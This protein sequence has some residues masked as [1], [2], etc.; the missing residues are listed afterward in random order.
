MLSAS[1]LILV[2]LVALLVF[3]PEKLPELARTLSKVMGDFNRL[4]GDFKE[5]IQREMDQI[6][7][8]VREKNRAKSDALPDSQGA[9]PA[10]ASES[11][12]AAVSEEASSAGEVANGEA[13][14]DAANTEIAEDSSE[15]LPYDDFYSTYE[16]MYYDGDMA[17]QPGDEPEPISPET[18]SDQS[19]DAAPAPADG[20]FSVPDSDAAANPSS[21][22]DSSA[23]GSE[24]P[25]NGHPTAA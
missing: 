22:E 8:E 2:F 7:R 9:E 3:G 16:G 11:G 12:S 1:H 17:S 20:I 6:E 10:P 24:K 23:S 18:A 19:S 4:T 21:N 13:G 5:T 14:Q 25:V 15:N